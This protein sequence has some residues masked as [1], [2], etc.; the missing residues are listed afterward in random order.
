VNEMRVYS[1]AIRIVI[2]GVVFVIGLVAGTM[3]LDSTEAK[4]N[5]NPSNAQVS[6][7]PKNKNGQTYGSSADAISPYTEPYLIKAQGVNGTIGYVL[8]TDLDDK[9]PRN[10]AEA[11]ALQKSRPAGGRDIPLYDVEGNTVIGVFHIG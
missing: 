10:P 1:T 7:F 6:G 4:T 2:I 9:M 5:I 8:K 3:T 11:L